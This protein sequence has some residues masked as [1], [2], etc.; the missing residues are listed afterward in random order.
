MGTCIKTFSTYLSVCRP[1]D[2]GDRVVVLAGA[3]ELA[4]VLVPDAVA[5]VLRPR[6]DPVVG[7]R[8]VDA[9]D[10]RVVGAPLQ[11][12]RVGRKGLHRQQLVRRVNYLNMTSIIRR[13]FLGLPS[14][15]A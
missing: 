3:V 1:R 14:D 4:A 7:G 13:Q 9:E 15:M 6:D 2:S 5:A 11:R 12:L 10:E 8:P